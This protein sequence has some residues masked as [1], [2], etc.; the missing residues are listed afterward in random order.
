M[1]LLLGQV[2]Y[3]YFHH[4][5]KI[6]YLIFDLIFQPHIKHLSR[7]HHLKFLYSSLYLTQQDR[8]LQKD[9]LESQNQIKHRLYPK[10]VLLLKLTYS[11]LFV[12]EQEF[13]FLQI[14]DKLPLQ[15]QSFEFFLLLQVSLQQQ[16]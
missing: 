4:R 14:Q 2:I 15:Q 16:T 7:S 13:Y 8:T 12:F 5:H 9:P 11:P 1:L 10:A 6:L 3:F